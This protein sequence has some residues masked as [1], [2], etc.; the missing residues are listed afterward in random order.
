MP[1]L[2]YYHVEGHHVLVVSKT[3]HP[4]THHPR[5]ILG[6]SRTSFSCEGLLMTFIMSLFRS[7]SVSRTRCLL[8]SCVPKTFFV[9]NVPKFRSE[10]HAINLPITVPGQNVSRQII[11][12]RF[13]EAGPGFWEDVRTL[14]GGK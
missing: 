2:V 6:T 10:Y 7:K 5:A 3:R 14:I 12:E 9:Y 11:T 4:K 1:I 8:R 13:S